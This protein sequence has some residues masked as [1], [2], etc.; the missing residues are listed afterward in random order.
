MTRRMTLLVI[1]LLGLMVVVVTIA[2]P[3]TGRRG[4]RDAVATPQPPTPFLT[5]P[6]AFDVTAKLSAA[7]SAKPQTIEAVLGDRVEIVVDADEPGSVGLG[8]LGTEQMEPGVP[9]RFELLADTPGS[10]P[11]VV[12]D[13]QRRIGTLEVR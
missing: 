1:A 3:D 11:L 12:L 9:A 2:P 4:R 5:D 6:D 7:V 8:D 13:D 10:Y